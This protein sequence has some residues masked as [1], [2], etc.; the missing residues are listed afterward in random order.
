MIVDPSNDAFQTVLD[1]NRNAFMRD[2]VTRAEFVGLYP[3]TDTPTQYLDKLYLHAGIAPSA[4]ERAAAIA[5]VGC[6]AAAVDEGARVRALL[7]VTLNQ[8]F[9]Q[10]E[11]NRTFV[12]MQFFG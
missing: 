2:F 9:Q 8:T 11:V 12:Q 1:N 4:A 5:E 7:D 3:T 6:A 10:R